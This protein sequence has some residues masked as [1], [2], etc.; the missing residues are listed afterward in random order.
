MTLKIEKDSCYLSGETLEYKN[1]IKRREIYFFQIAFEIE[2]E[3][4]IN[5]I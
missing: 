3:N 4:P 1:V 2:V 5:K